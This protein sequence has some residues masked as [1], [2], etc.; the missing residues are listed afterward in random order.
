V[1]RK[2]TALPVQ[3]ASSPLTCVARGAG[4]SLDNLIALGSRSRRWKFR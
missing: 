3:I 2:E 4:S 1:L